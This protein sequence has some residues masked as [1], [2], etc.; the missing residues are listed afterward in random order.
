MFTGPFQIWNLQ[1]PGACQVLGTCQKTVAFVHLTG[2]LFPA[3]QQA[4]FIKE[5]P[6]KM[7]YPDSPY[8]VAFRPF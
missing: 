3:M 5:K 1:R 2:T 8:I 6:T 4:R 7:D